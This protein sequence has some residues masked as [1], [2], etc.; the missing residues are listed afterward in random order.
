MGFAV[1]RKSAVVAAVFI[2]AMH[3]AASQS[4]SAPTQNCGDCNQA[5]GGSVT[6]FPDRFRPRKSRL[7]VSSHRA[8]SLP[9]LPKHVLSDPED[10]DGAILSQLAVLAIAIP[11]AGD[12][13]PFLSRHILTLWQALQERVDDCSALVNHRKGIQVEHQAQLFIENVIAGSDPTIYQ[14]TDGAFD[15]VYRRV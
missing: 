8:G 3:P 9:P 1:D 10:D 4:G 2:L 11:V 15:V 13:F 7:L 5:A 12:L 14:I 6:D